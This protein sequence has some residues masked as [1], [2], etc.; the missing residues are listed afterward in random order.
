MSSNSRQ[1][2]IFEA[3]ESRTLFAAGGVDFATSVNFNNVEATAHDA[4][5]Q[6]DGKTVVVGTTSDGR[7]AVSR[8]KADG[9]IDNSFGPNHDGKAF[10]RPGGLNDDALAVALEPNGNIIV[11]GTGRDVGGQ[12]YAELVRFLPNGSID[13]TFGG[14]P[15]SRGFTQCDLDCE[16][17][18]NLRDIALQ[19]DG[20]IVVVGT[21]YNYHFWRP[22][23]TDMIV[24]RFNANGSLDESFGDGGH[25]FIGADGGVEAGHA[26]AIDRNTGNIVVVGT[27]RLIN[28]FSMMMVGRLNSMGNF[29]GSFNGGQAKLLFA[30]NADAEG[31]TIQPGG[32][33]VMTGSSQGDMTS[34]RLLGNGLLDHT[35]GELESNGTREGFVTTEILHFGGLGTDVI[36][37][38]SGAL[39]VG[40]NSAAN[41]GEAAVV[42]YTANGDLD[43]S[44]GNQ[45]VADVVYP[46]HT[47]FARLA[48]G[49]GLRFVAVGG[50][51]KFN[52][53][54]FLDA[55]AGQVS[56]TPLGNN[57][58]EVGP[59]S[60]A[61]LVQRSEQLPFATRVYFTV[62][63]TAT[64]PT[65]LSTRLKA[66]DYA[67]TNLH[68]D[69]LAGN[70]GYVDIPAYSLST[71]VTL[72]PIV[73]S[74][75]E[76]TETATFAAVANPS[77]SIVGTTTAV[78]INIA[79]NDSFHI[80]KLPVTSAMTTATAT[81]NVW[82]E[83]PIAA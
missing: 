55:G 62:G 70:R 69:P 71:R 36:Q 44:F 7:F 56:I 79:D 24:G 72:T 68:I 37:D 27:N 1:L 31:V 65:I 2:S 42:K 30:G 5:V 19:R 60:G 32:K 13:P 22:S 75:I 58:S 20:R 11:A 54:R 53:V 45:G 67:M 41:G 77:Y 43:T 82:S 76:G 10:A 29:D 38:T 3:L 21:G 28:S 81:T 4:V 39:L 35:F 14:D 52:V 49:P 57:A 80:T 9:S 50:A 25:R 74:A 48:P 12:T 16:Q 17:R 83:L 51:L 46:D 8:L 23:T 73:D 59:T 64:A 78:T 47:G 18:S 61:F 26:V 34:V 40:S 15:T 6:P 63:G 33:I 66:A